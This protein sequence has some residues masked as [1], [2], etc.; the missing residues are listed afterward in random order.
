MAVLLR[1]ARA[2][3]S[4]TPEKA[5]DLLT[6]ASDEL[7]SAL[8]ELRELA[9]GIH[10]SV[11]TEHG[12]APALAALA[13]RSTLAVELAE[14]P[15]GRFPPP[16]EAAVYF[17]VSEA[18]ANADKHAEASRVRVR[19]AAQDGMLVAE[20]TD[21]GRGGAEEAGGSG[22][23]G[24]ADRVEA[25][26]GRLEVDS[27]RARGPP[28]AALLPLPVGAP[29]GKLRA[30]SRQP[31]SPPVRI[32]V[33]AVQGNF[34]EHAE[35]LRRL[36]AEPVEVRKPEHL[37]GLDGLIV[38]GG[39]STAIMRLIRLYGLE[40]GDQE[41][42][43]AGVRDVRRDDPARSNHLGLVDLAVDRNAYG[44]QVHSFE[45]DLDLVGEDEPLRG[46]FIRAPR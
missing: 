17:V 44:R 29:V 16:H 30:E 33:L 24:L 43:G 46:V 37:V 26:A 19:V 6:T 28:C 39:E 7:A 32:G 25:L 36:G 22:L 34:R 2:Q 45:A 15:E 14:P 9:R 31:L 41:L 12:L 20:I 27:A 21:D 8:A 18:L 35:V 10:P 11:L 42:P 23:R 38:P 3:L 13:R 5:A 4:S 40:E 1:L